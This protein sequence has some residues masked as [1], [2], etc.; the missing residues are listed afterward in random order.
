M[1]EKGRITQVRD[2]FRNYRAEATQQ[3]KEYKKKEKKLE[4]ELAEL[5]SS[6][7]YKMKVKYDTIKKKFK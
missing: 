1:Y 3:I 4:K 5:K 7:F 2:N 6:R